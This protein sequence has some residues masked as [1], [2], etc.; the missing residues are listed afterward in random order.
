LNSL[1]PNSKTEQLSPYD[2]ERL[3]RRG[4]RRVLGFSCPYVPHMYW[5][6][7][8]PGYIYVAVYGDTYK[9]G[10]TRI[11]GKSEAVYTTWGELAGVRGRMN[12]LRKE[13]GQPFKLVHLI[14]TPVCVKGVEKFIHEQLAHGR[15]EKRERFELDEYDLAW[16]FSFEAFD[17]YLLTHME[18]T[19]CHAE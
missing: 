4:H 5:A 14:Y 17:G 11:G 15:L 2:I 1:H 9:I 13:S 18:A 7:C 3:Q 16:L 12:S 19:V 8:G 6:Y 10:C